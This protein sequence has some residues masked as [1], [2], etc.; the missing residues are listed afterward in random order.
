MDSLMQQRKALFITTFIEWTQS[1][2]SLC[3]ISFQRCRRLTIARKFSFFC[4]CSIFGLD[5]VVTFYDRRIGWNRKWM[6]KVRFHDRRVSIPIEKSMRDAKEFHLH[7]TRLSLLLL[8]RSSVSSR[9]KTC[10]HLSLRSHKIG[11]FLF[12]IQKSL[13]KFRLE[14]DEMAT[15]TV[16]FFSWFESPTTDSEKNYAKREMKNREKKLFTRWQTNRRSIASS[17]INLLRAIDDLFFLFSLRF[18][19]FPLDAKCLIKHDYL[20]ELCSIQDY[21]T[22]DSKFTSHRSN[23]VLRTDWEI[24]S[25]DNQIMQSTTKWDERTTMRLFTNKNIEN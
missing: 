3:A 20:L 23:E 2:R 17:F 1:E 21:V 8:L 24:Q 25:I 19:D 11:E 12:R 7:A 4:F 13:R 18:D 14:N 5:V 6:W 22:R 16:F 9:H 10:F 15:L